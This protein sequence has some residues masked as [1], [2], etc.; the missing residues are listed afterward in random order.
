MRQAPTAQPAQG[1]FQRGLLILQETAQGLEG[2]R[3][4]SLE[5]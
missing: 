2:L 1:P 4:V 5:D 3:F